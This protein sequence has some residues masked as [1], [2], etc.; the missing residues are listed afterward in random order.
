MESCADFSELV[1]IIIMVKLVVAAT[2]LEISLL[3]NHLN[4]PPKETI[5]GFD[6]YA[7]K[8][9]SGTIHVVKSDPGAANAAA[10]TAVA[11]NRF[12]PEK[13]FNIGI[14]GAYSE[15]KNLLAEAV[16]GVAAIFAD[17][18]VATDNSFDL[19]ETID[20][21]LAETEKNEKVFNKIRLN[22]PDVSKNVL[23][24]V[25]LTAGAVSGSNKIAQDIKSRFNTAENIL[26]CEDMESAAVALIALKASVPCTVI[27]GISNLCGNQN[28]KTWMLMEA[29]EAAQKQVIKHL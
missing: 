14:C 10:A 19:L 13:I 4:C 18:G 8:S 16:A 21:Q 27:R 3:V 22:N 29:A 12:Q 26:L 15:D 6:F 25:F 1:G 20:L 5:I 2:T 11:V 7:A 9:S 23:H 24:G 17:A 28:R